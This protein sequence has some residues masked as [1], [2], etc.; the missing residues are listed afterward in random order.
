VAVVP[1]PRAVEAA[2]DKEVLDASTGS[3]LLSQKMILFSREV[4]ERVSTRLSLATLATFVV[5]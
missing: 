4:T 5:Y 1:A 3:T 2:M